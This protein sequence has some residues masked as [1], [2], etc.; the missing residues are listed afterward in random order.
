MY[1]RYGVDSFG[2]FLIGAMFVLIVLSIFIR[3]WIL[4]VL[5]WGV[6]IYSYFRMFSRNIPKRYAENQKFLSVTGGV[7][8]FIR[9]RKKRFDDRGEYRHFTCPKCRTSFEKNV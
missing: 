7:R 8:K 4:Q 1:G 9:I 5:I 3:S 6:L 2:R